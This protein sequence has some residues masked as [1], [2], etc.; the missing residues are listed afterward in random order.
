MVWGITQRGHDHDVVDY[1]IYLWQVGTP[2]DSAVRLTHHSGN[3]RW[4]DIFIPSAVAAKATPLAPEPKPA[5][6]V[7][8]APAPAVAQASAKVAPPEPA[9]D[10]ALPKKVK[11]P[12]KGKHK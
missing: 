11:R 9:S 10:E 1:E 8:S 5:A 2:P 6:A 12:K 7:A 3:D 4:P